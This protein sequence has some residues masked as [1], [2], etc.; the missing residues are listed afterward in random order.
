[1]IR[2]VDVEPQGFKALGFR[3]TLARAEQLA[4]YYL[5]RGIDVIVLRER[6]Q[7]SYW[8]PASTLYTIGYDDYDCGDI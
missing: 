8:V 1:M 5:K 2:I 7:K 3:S 4:E 6:T